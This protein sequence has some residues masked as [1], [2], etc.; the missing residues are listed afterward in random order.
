MSEIRR[1]YLTTQ[2]AGFVVA[3]YKLPTR[4]D[5]ATGQPVPIIST[6][7]MLTEREAKY[8]LLSGSII[9]EIEAKPTDYA[10]LKGGKKR[11]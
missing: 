9:E 11:R 8:E 5:P 7:L 4:T 3:K 6:R 1:P 10:G 2:A